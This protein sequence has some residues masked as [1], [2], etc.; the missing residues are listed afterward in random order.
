MDMLVSIWH[1]KL[2]MYRLVVP[3]VVA[4]TIHDPR[5]VKGKCGLVKVA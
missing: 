5:P 4:Q 1:Q 3:S 2:R